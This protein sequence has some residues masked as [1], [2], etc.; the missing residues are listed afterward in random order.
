MFGYKNLKDTIKS[1]VAVLTDPEDTSTNPQP[2]FRNVLG[3]KPKKPV[4]YKGPGAIVLL[5]NA[6]N[7]DW[8]GIHKQKRL[9]VVQGAVLTFIPGDDE[10]AMDKCLHYSDIV[11]DIFEDRFSLGIPGTQV[12]PVKGMSQGWRVVDLSKA[13]DMNTNQLKKTTTAATFFNVYKGKEKT[14]K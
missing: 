7:T 8:K 3:G 1:K 11:G 2:I 5:A 4:F 10:K 6:S 12:E 14:K 9:S 13:T